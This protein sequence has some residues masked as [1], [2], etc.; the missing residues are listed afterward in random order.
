MH[1]KNTSDSGILVQ[2]PSEARL[3]S[4]LNNE[5]LRPFLNF[6]E[7]LLCI[8]IILFIVWSNHE[9][10]FMDVLRFNF[11]FQRIKATNGTLVM[12]SLRHF[13]CHQIYWYFWMKWNL[14]NLIALM[15]GVT[16]SIYNWSPD[17]FRLLFSKNCLNWKFTAMIIL[18][19]QYLT[20]IFCSFTVISFVS[21][22]SE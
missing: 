2:K 15:Q 22:W 11:W 18:H 16:E 5:V 12:I 9:R 10:F 1:G 14:I 13:W 19:F 3:S 8:M 7:S 20:I 17:F 4:T 6:S 21:I